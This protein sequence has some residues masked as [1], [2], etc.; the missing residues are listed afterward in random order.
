MPP[1]LYDFDPADAECIRRL[2]DSDVRIY[3]D[4]ILPSGRR[5][6]G[7]KADMLV[8]QVRYD[9]YEIPAD[10]LAGAR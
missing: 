10:V 1:L 2:A 6:A 3:G 8:L 5:M 9:P 7:T 4:I